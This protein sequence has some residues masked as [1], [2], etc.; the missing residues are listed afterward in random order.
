MTVN[1]FQPQLGHRELAAVS[2]V[3]ESNWLGYG[4]RSK[5]FEAAFADHLG[6]PADRT[7]FLNSG[8]AG[9]FLAMELL[10]LREGDE[11]VLPSISFV[12]A[13]NAVAVTGARPVFCDVGPHTPNPTAD[14]VEAKLTARTKAVIVLHYGGHPGDVARIAALCRHRGIPLVEDAACAVASRVDGRACGTFGDMAMWSFDAMKVLVT[15]DGGMLH[16]R[17]PDLAARS[18]ALAYHGLDQTSGY[19]KARVSHRWWELNVLRPGR[20]HIGNDLTAAIGLV[21]LERLPEFLK[22]RAEVAEFYDAALADVVRV[23]PPLPAGHETSHYSYWVRMDPAWRDAVAADLLA[24]GI[25]TTFRYPPL[26]KVPA[27][28]SAE[29]LP[30]AERASDETLC[31]PLHQSLTDEDL[32]RVVAELRRSL[33]ARA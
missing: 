18:R 15:G 7:V 13:A 33:A 3:F 2:E 4:T 8:S 32:H 1:V 9:L 5:A 22:R 12:A 16:V 26:H 31:L 28:G 24:A 10:D 11:V 20:R 19:Q 29:V 23:P 21:Q 17:D 27:Y 30:N 25:Y 14:D 6:V